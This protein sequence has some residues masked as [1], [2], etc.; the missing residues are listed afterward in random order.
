MVVVVVVVVV[1]MMVVV[2]VGDAFVLALESVV[3]GG[4]AMT[5]HEGCER[6]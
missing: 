6:D 4:V 5:E 2:V 1:V 3:F